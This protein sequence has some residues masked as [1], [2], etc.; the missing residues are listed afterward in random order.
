MR[1][2]PLTML[3]NGQVKLAKEVIYQDLPEEEY[4]ALLIQLGIPEGFAGILA[5]S[6]E[7][8]SKGGLYS[9]SK[10][11]HQLIGRATTSMQETI[12]EFLS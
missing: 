7:G 2:I 12:K 11:L 4:K 6:D 8:V 10:D 5:D 3:Q 9:D 1:V